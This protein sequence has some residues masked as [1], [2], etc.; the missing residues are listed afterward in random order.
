M[1]GVP[2]SLTSATA[3]LAETRDDPLALGLARMV[4]VIGHRRLGAGMCASSFALTLLS[5]AST[6]SARRN[7]SAARGL[8]SPR[9][10]IGVATM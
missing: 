5:S 2:A 8:K 1:S 6:R 10:P 3:S 4:V 9:F 7:V